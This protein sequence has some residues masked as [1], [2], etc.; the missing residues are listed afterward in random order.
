MRKE[1]SVLAEVL[2]G[3]A[4]GGSLTGAGRGARPCERQAR[5]NTGFS[6]KYT[7]R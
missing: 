3:G 4:E 2:R 6:A 7:W 5:S 1:L